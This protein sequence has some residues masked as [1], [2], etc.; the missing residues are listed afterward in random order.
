[1]PSTCDSGSVFGCAISSIPWIIGILLAIVVVLLAIRFA[2]AWRERRTQA[3]SVPP[4]PRAPRAVTPGSPVQPPVGGRHDPKPQ[5][6]RQPAKPT[7]LQLRV[8]D[9]P[10]LKV[11]HF[12]SAAAEEDF[13]AL[14]TDVILTSEGWKKLESRFT[15]GGIDGLYVREVRGGG[16]FEALAVE[17]KTN[18]AAFDPASMSDTKLEKDL[19]ALYA[20]GAF[21]K[22]LN[23][24][25]ANELIRGLRNGAP[26]FRKEL[27]RHNLSN[28]MTAITQ[29]G[30]KGE[31]KASALRSHARLVTGSYIALKQIDRDAVYVGERPVGE[32]N[33]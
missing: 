17:T 18:E 15:G 11:S 5:P 7:P 8:E 16:G 32:A 3:P 4:A 24:A 12:T 10:D 26:F 22:T 30:P 6:P 13:G 20:H 19:S 2:L 23:E 27:W 25:V 1:M 14:L 9:R 31:Q 21:G 29:L 33:P 28:G